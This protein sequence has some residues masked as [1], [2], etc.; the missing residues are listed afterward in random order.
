MGLIKPMISSPFT[1]QITKHT[2]IQTPACETSPLQFFPHGSQRTL[3]AP[4]PNLIGPNFYSSS[5]PKVVWFPSRCLIAIVP[6][7]LCF[8]QHPHEPKFSALAAFHELEVA[9]LI[10]SKGIFISNQYVEVSIFMQ[11]IA[12]VN[13][14]NIHLNSSV[15]LYIYVR[16]GTGVDFDTALKSPQNLKLR[17]GG[18]QH[19]CV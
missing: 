2:Y 11:R 15:N 5:L 3:H 16:S 7:E 14:I 9:L 8:Y 12:H 13:I 4:F 18:V 17:I 1:L 6:R 19:V 10:E